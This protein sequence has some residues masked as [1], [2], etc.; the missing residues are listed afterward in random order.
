MVTAR[1]RQPDACL[2]LHTRKVILIVEG[3]LEQILSSIRRS[4]VGSGRRR[5]GDIFGC[6]RK[7]IFLRSQALSAYVKCGEEVS[8]FHASVSLSI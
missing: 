5:I 1:G 4:I 8:N 6:D 2:I 7:L 3:S